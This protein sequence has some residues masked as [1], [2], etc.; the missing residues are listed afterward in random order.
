MNKEIL[1]L[2]AQLKDAF[3][4]DPWFGRSVLALLNEVTEEIA[5]E[6]LNGQHSIV[7]LIWHMINW[8]EFAINCLHPD[9][10]R[11]LHYF[12]ENDWKELD[13]SDKSLF[14]KG[15]KEIQK[16]QD[17]FIKILQEQRDQ[18]LETMVPER[19]YT[20]R[21]ILHGV[22]QHDIYHL[23]QIAYIKKVLLNV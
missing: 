21:K 10:D 11:N 15:I 14:Q 23:G 16:I 3:E 12:E 22:L 13:L 8:K 7:E 19:A 1:F 5:F 4:G 18:I 9:R 17:D 6:K 20:F 2:A